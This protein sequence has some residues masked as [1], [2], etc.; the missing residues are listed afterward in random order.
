[1]SLNE[2]STLI[3]ESRK[4]VEAAHSDTLEPNVLLNMILQIVTNIDKRIEIMETT[5]IKSVDDL[6]KEILSVSGR[7]RKLENLSTDL[8][9]K[10]TECESSCQGVSNLFDNADKQIKTN[11]RNIIHQDQRLRKLE[12]NPNESNADRSQSEKM[13]CLHQRIRVLESKIKSGNTSI[14]Q[15]PTN[16][17]IRELQE[18]VIDLQCRSMKNNLIFTNLAEQPTEDVEIKLRTF[19]FEKLG[20]EHKIEIGNVH[21][22]GKRYNDRPRPI[23]ARFLYHKDLRMVLDQATWLKNTPFGIH[24]Q[25]PKPIEDKRRKLYPVLKD[26]KRQGK[27]AVLVRDKLFINGSQYFVDDTDEATHVNRISYRDS[28]LTTPKEADRPYKR[29]RRSDSSPLVTGNAY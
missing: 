21:R 26:A 29:Q 2:T 8:T 11:T 17:E 18:S 25:F 7:V 24:Q 23:V 3:A 1:M 20:I 28:L 12:E 6:K 19:I 14:S 9:V 4:I 16:N 15:I 22:F 5:M 13:E 27:H 10:V